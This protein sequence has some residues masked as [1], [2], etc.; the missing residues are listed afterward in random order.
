MPASDDSNMGQELMDLMQADPA[1]ARKIADVIEQHYSS[2]TE[3]GNQSMNEHGNQGSPMPG[4]EGNPAATA[5]AGGAVPAGAMGPVSAPAA[6]ISQAPAMGPAQGAPEMSGAQQ[7]MNIPP[8]L[9]NRLQNV[10]RG[11][12]QMSLDRELAEAKNDYQQIKEQLPILPDLNDKE[13]LQVSYNKGG[14]PLKDALIYWAWNK[15][16]EG[17]GEGTLADRIMAQK[18]NQSQTGGLPKVEGKGGGIP[19]GAEAPPESMK[20][21]RQRAKN[22]IFARFAQPNQ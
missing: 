19:S 7:Q 6:P 4:M 8:E 3:G 22:E 18:M 15:L 13:L 5:P 20:E 16:Q 17:S 14:M 11:Q 12:A 21:A 1:L 10:E 2:N 9:I